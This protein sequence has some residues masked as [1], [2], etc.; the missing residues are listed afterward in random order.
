MIELWTDGAT[1]N[2][3]KVNMTGG[4]A[5]VIVK[6]GKEYCR[7]FGSESNATNNRCEYLAMLNGLK[8]IEEEFGHFENVSCFSDSM[9]LIKTL[10]EW[11]FN[12]KKQG[13]V[14]KGGKEI[15]NFDLV[16]ALYPYACNNKFKFFHVKGHAGVKWNE[17]C[18]ELAVKARKFL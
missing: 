1:S 2:N 18:D 16:Q 13:W 5:Y 8:R 4:W 17:L 10:N 7:G 12:W 3:G 11:I 6:D 9:L 14:R 15:K